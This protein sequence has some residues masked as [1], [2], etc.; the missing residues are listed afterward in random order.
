L[1]FSI[2]KRK[3]N[4]IRWRLAVKSLLLVGLCVLG[5]YASPQFVENAAGQCEAAAMRMMRDEA[6]DAGRDEAM[7]AISRGIATLV[8][9]TAMEQ[10]FRSMPSSASC[11]ILYWSAVADPK[12]TRENF[13]SR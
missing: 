6:K 3:Y 8:V 11:A 13:A 1:T 9:S 12:G 10:K 5:A 4:D 2:K 7:N